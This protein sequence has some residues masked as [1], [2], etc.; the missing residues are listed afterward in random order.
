MPEVVLRV[1]MSCGGCSGAVE[2]ILKKAEGE[3]PGRRR[4]SA[5][6]FS[7]DQTNRRT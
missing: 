4:Q 5:R 7:K 6:H 3:P 2:R 1:A